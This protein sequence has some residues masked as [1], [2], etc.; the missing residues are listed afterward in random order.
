MNTHKQTQREDVIRELWERSQEICVQPLLSRSAGASIFL[1]WPCSAP[2]V[3]IQ[4][5]GLS[6]CMCLCMSVCISETFVSLIFAVPCV[7][8]L[9]VL[10]TLASASVSDRSVMF[11]EVMLRTS[12][13]TPERA[14][15][16]P[17]R[18]HKVSLGR[19]RQQR[20]IGFTTPSLWRQAKAPAVPSAFE[21]IVHFFPRM[22]QLTSTHN[23]PWSWAKLV[24]KL[25]MIFLNL[26]FEVWWAS[27]LTVLLLLTWFYSH[28]FTLNKHFSARGNVWGV[29]GPINGA[30]ANTTGH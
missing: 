13:P 5:Q 11:S 24:A 27:P 20:P 26:D 14:V 22:W 18:I 21:W 17:F 1:I 7:H 23:F 9:A 3:S 10:H 28:V 2:D 6:P 12:P 4:H 30:F 15:L 16:T 29:C 8:W 19:Q 25:S